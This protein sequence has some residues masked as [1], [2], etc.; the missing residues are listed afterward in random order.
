MTL[1][2]QVQFI[3]MAESRLVVDEALAL[4]L[5]RL[6]MEEDILDTERSESP[7]TTVKQTMFSAF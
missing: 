6:N 3:V 2:S 5:Q 4:C 7:L 1:S